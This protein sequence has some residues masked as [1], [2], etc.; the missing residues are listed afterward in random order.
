MSQSQIS[1]S[2][3]I[4]LTSVKV[5]YIYPRSMLSQPLVQELHPYRAQHAGFCI[6]K[7]IEAW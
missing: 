1:K 3:E 5:F 7:Q 6:M 4:R 2:K